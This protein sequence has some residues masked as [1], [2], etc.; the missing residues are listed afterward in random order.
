MLPYKLPKAV[1]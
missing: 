1:H